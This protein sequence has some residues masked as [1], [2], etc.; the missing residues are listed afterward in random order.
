[1]DAGKAFY[2]LYAA[3]IKGINP[4]VENLQVEVEFYYIEGS[5]S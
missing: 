1:M 5:A 4:E 2:Q 3:L